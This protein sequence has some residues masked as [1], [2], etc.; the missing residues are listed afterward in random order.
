MARPARDGDGSSRMAVAMLVVIGWD[1]C[2]D[3][4][5]RLGTVMVV[6]QGGQ[7]TLAVGRD[8]NGNW[9]GR[10]WQSAG[11]P[12]TIVAI[13]LDDQGRQWLSA[14]TA[15][16]GGGSWVGWPRCQWWSN[17]TVVAV[18]LGDRRGGVIAQLFGEHGPKKPLF[19]LNNHRFSCSYS[20]VG[21]DVRIC[22]SV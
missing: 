14:R 3:R 20:G 2:S 21:A 7:D 6:G 12:G 19:F 18:G 22:P 13:V 17:G 10:W 16:D 5:G 1:G 4:A 11:R 8:D 15:R 9:M